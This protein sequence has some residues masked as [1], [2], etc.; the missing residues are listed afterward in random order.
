MTFGN[1]IDQDLRIKIQDILGI[2][3]KGDADTYL[4]LPECFSG[5]KRDLL[6]YIQDVEVRFSPINI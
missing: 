3:N 6:D 5:S 4:G 2:Y 1:N